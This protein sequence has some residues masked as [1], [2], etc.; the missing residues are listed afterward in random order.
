MSRSRHH[1]CPCG[2]CRMNHTSMT[3]GKRAREAEAGAIDLEAGLDDIDTDIATPDP[4]GVCGYCWDNYTAGLGCA[5]GFDCGGNSLS[6]RAALAGVEYHHRIVL[7][8]ESFAK[9]SEAIANPRP[10]NEAL[11]KLF[12]KGTK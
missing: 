6:M 10:P 5:D 7:D 9:L 4:I 3:E 2:V 1:G 8:E 12:D 11:R